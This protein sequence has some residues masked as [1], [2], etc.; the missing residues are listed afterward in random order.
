MRIFDEVKFHNAQELA[1]F[2]SILIEKNVTSWDTADIYG[3]Y[4]VEEQLGKAIALLPEKRGDY[5]LITKCGVQLLSESR[6]DTCV[7]HYNTRADYI[8]QSAEQSL[9]KLGLDV[10]DVFLIHR[11]DYLADADEIALALDKLC[12]SG[13]VKHVGVSNY[14]PSQLSLLQ[15]RI[16]N[17][18]C[19]NQIEFSPLYLDPIFNGMFDQAQQYSMRPMIW[20]P[21]AGGKIFDKSFNNGKL[22][23]L[24]ILP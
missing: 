10:L 12:E 17:T 14:M 15:S 22:Y 19:T 2:L 5:Q 20:S 6:P 9:K 3:S 8:I 23:N 18:L 7:H 1:K 16:K 4:Q 13:K 24:F 11:P 21:F